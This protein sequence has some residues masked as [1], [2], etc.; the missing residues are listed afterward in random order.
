MHTL[1]SILYHM[2]NSIPYF[3]FAFHLFN[4]KQQYEFQKISIWMDF[5]LFLFSKNSQIC[6]WGATAWR[7]HMKL[8]FL[9]RIASI[10]FQK[11][12][13]MVNIRC[14]AYTKHFGNISNHW[15]LKPLVSGWSSL[16][17]FH[18]KNQNLEFKQWIDATHISKDT[19]LHERF[20]L[21]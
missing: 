3:C 8:R 10:D 4:Q 6:P 12:D 15:T 16:F 1:R 13:R 14:I 11:L 7:L 21:K 2:T 20:M 9:K 19:N 17:W 18:I 5:G